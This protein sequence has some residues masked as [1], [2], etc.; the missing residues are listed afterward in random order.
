[1]IFLALIECFIFITVILF[2]GNWCQFSAKAA[3]SFNAMPRYFPKL[4]FYAIEV[5]N[6]LNI[7]SQFAVVALP[8]V[9]GNSTFH[10]NLWTFTGFYE[11]GTCIP[12]LNWG[13][14][15]FLLSIEI[16][17]DP[18]NCIR[19]HFSSHTLMVYVSV[20]SLIYILIYKTKRVS[21]SYSRD[22]ISKIC[23]F[24]AYC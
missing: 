2:Y 9:L 10:L 3:P 4:N 22:G 13:S 17:L 12:I 1:M 23:N 18:D 16:Q 6:N 7:F 20:E 15:D 5:A 11:L 21:V 8:S 14:W 19:V 24:F